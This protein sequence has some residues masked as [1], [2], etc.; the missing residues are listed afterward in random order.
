MPIWCVF[1]DML[2][3]IVSLDTTAD[4]KIIFI[5]DFI[6][7]QLFSVHRSINNLTMHACVECQSTQETAS[8]LIYVLI[9]VADKASLVGFWAHYMQSYLLSFLLT[10]LTC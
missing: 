10:L 7:M 3:E 1:K 9:R 6:R 8:D 5:C 4:P 2:C